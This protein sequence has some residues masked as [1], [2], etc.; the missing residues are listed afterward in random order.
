M[1]QDLLGNFKETLAKRIEDGQKNGV[2][3]FVQKQGVMQMADLL[4]NFSSPKTPE[5]AL[6]KAM[7]EEAGE[8]EKKVLVDLIF[9]MGENVKH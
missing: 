3:E 6:V 2:P 9:K 8:D 1:P 7:W 5:E 4:V